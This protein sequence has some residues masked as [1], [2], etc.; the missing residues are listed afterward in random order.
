M[1]LLECP[2]CLS[3]FDDPHVLPGCGHTFCAAC[4][5]GVAGRGSGRC[6]QCRQDFQARHV[7]PNFA[8]RALMDEHEAADDEQ[9]S[10]PP[11]EVALEGTECGVLD[12]PLMRTFAEHP[13]T[14][15]QTAAALGLPPHLVQLLM[16]ED[17]NVALRM[18]ILDDSYSTQALDGHYLEEAPRGGMTRVSCSRWEEIKRTVVE[19]AKWNARMG[20][21]C[22]FTMLNRKSLHARRVG[23]DF[24]HVDAAKGDSAAQVEALQ[25]MLDEH[26]PVGGTPLVKCIQE[27]HQRIKHDHSNLI[28][29]GQRV[30][31][32]ILTDG[33]PA[34]GSLTDF[35]RSMV[36]LA[37][38]CPVNI[39]LRLCT[40]DASTVRF[41]NQIE[42]DFELPLDVI[43]DITA[44][45]QELRQHGNGWFAYTPALHRLRE[46][47]TFM[48][49][50]DLLDER[51]LTA[52]EAALLAQLLLR[53]GQS[54]PLPR[55][56]T[57]FCEAARC[58]LQAAAPVYDAFSGR[59]VPPVGM[60]GLR[61]ALGLGFPALQAVC[62]R[63][64]RDLCPSE[65]VVRRRHV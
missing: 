30:F 53:D 45:A 41:Y 37:N 39:V 24:M 49:L 4:I 60:R 54:P 35:A 15:L 13:G 62:C 34:D 28:S 8:L 19:H 10:A 12:M 5:Q 25:R 42:E 38:E 1:D 59:L 9:P 20:T 18:F 3:P 57:A 50:L 21:P 61:L 64:K 55:E 31:L 63:R 65:R 32:I 48:K 23:I 26:N 44:E 6:P 52:N 46:G 51:Q 36:K 58:L 47:G 17:R 40:D 29:A 16:Q 11:A 22:E 14:V 56:P 33:Q 7:R 2:V 43:D 27:I